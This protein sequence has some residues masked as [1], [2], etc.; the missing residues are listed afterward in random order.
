MCHQK[1]RLS[2]QLHPKHV[3]IWMNCLQFL[4]VFLKYGFLSKVTISMFTVYR[5]KHSF[6]T[7]GRVFLWRCQR[8]WDGKWVGIEPPTFGFMPNA[9]TIWAIILIWRHILLVIYWVRF[10]LVKLAWLY[11]ACGLW[12]TAFA[13]IP[14]KPTYNRSPIACHWTMPTIYN[15]CSKRYNN[16]I[17]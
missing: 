8:F 1:R 6:S 9:L 13:K 12:A 11:Q 5:Q 17:D 7:H 2:K 3:F 4:S 16:T 10:V 14:Y 15:K